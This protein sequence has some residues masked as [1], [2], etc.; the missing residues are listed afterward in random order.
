MLGARNSSQIDECF[1]RGRLKDLDVYHNSQIFSGLPRQS[2]R[3]NSDIIILLKQ[4]FRDIES[5][6]RDIGGYDTKHDEFE[7]ICRKAWSDKFIYLCFDITEK[8]NDGIYPRSNESK[9]TYFEC[10]C[11]GEAF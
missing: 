4:T 2:I 8:K 5:M 11:E 9:K 10:L 1:T 7:K 6:Y 3:N